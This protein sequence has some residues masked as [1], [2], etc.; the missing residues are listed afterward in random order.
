MRWRP[1]LR[2]ALTL[3]Q[4]GAED[5][6]ALQRALP[7]ATF[8]QWHVTIP[9]LIVRSAAMELPTG[10]WTAFV[11]R[12]L[13]GVRRRPLLR[14]RDIAGALSHLSES[15]RVLAAQSLAL[16]SGDPVAAAGVMAG[17]LEA[18]QAMGWSDRARRILIELPQTTLSDSQARRYLAAVPSMLAAMNEAGTTAEQQAELLTLAPKRLSPSAPEALA[19][20]HQLAAARLPWTDR[21]GLTKW[22]LKEPEA[23]TLLRAHPENALA[24][25]R[26]CADA[27]G[28]IAILD[29]LMEAADGVYRVSPAW[30]TAE[31]DWAAEAAVVAAVVQAGW[32]RALYPMLGALIGA[33]ARP[34]LS[35]RWDTTHQEWLGALARLILQ[36]QHVTPAAAANAAL[37]LAAADQP[38]G[39]V[40]EL[41]RDL[42]IVFA[43]VDL[44]TGPAHAQWAGLA[45]RLQRLHT[46][47][48]HQRTSQGI[49]SAFNALGNFVKAQLASAKA[50]RVGNL[51]L[52]A[53]SDTDGAVSLV[54]GGELSIP[55]PGENT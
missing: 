55:D 31:R 16:T 1:R 33:R 25:T 50:D 20:Q 6:D 2:R 39:R 8:W 40:V 21:M 38:I 27:P 35:L 26:A 44:E 48:D 22:C 9:R 7:Q 18:A 46:L 5:A 45:D 24:L 13:A 37:L 30:A 29:G 15:D 3:A 52:V 34:P 19:L 28:R 32:P 54:A 12:L 4:R 11:A 14:V 49:D 36:G 17:A 41:A 23:A 43:A 10:A 42:G 47:K 51:A 53:P